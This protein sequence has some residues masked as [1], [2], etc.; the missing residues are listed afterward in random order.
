MGDSFPQDDEQRRALMDDIFRVHFSAV[1]RYI[2]HRVNQ[3]DVIDDLTSQVFLKAIRWLRED[4]G[5]GQVRRWLYATAR[6]TIAEHW[7]EQQKNLFLPLEKIADSAVVSIETQ[8]DEQTRKYVSHLLHLL[9][10]RE[11]R[12]LILRYFQGYSTAEVGQEL[13]LQVGHVRVLQLRALRHAALIEAKERS[14]TLMSE[15]TDEPITVYTEQGQRI[16]DLAKEEALSFNHHYIGTEHLLLGILSEGSVAA[17]L[18]EQGATLSRSRAEILSIVGKNEPDPRAGA[19]FTPRSQTILKM[20]GRKARKQGEE[21]ITPE[22]ILQ[23]VIQEKDGIAVQLLRLMGVNLD[24]WLSTEKQPAEKN[25]QIIRKMEQQNARFPRLDE[26]EERRLAHLI[27][28]GRAEQRRAEL[29]KE[30]P[31]PSLVSEGDRAYFQL[32][33]TCQDLVLAVAREYLVPGRDMR[34]LIDAANMGISLA[35]ITFGLKRNTPF[36]AYALHQ[37]HLQIIESLE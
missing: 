3:P 29:L 7:Q 27:A 35:A 23:A 20:A 8:H 18:I 14:L 30:T 21:A 37:I 32:I 33:P 22:H 25:E 5:V 1:Q 16:L 28:R 11:R 26:E 15:L 12:V 17:P 9:P 4:L 24:A 19:P 6:T 13:G 31:D 36:R 10:E 2:A 34:D